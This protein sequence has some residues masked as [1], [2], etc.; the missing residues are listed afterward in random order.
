MPELSNFL[1]EQF[2]RA[3]V[4]LGFDAPRAYQLVFKPQ[5]DKR[6]TPQLGAS[7]LRRTDII[8][9]VEELI[10]QLTN[11]TGRT[12]KKLAEEYALENLEHLQAIVRDPDAKELVRIKAAQV[13]ME[14]GLGRPMQEV[15]VTKTTTFVI[16]APK[17]A[18][19]FEAWDT[20]WNGKTI[21]HQPVEP[22]A[23]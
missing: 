23:S 1:H 2:A 19:S 4:G 11:R 10:E 9:R 15:Q 3:Y 21:E 20:R 16:E 6:L 22:G 18:E 12:V 17:P 7:L 14:Y 5:I 8:T 13:V